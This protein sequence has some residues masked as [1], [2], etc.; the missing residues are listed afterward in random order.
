MQAYESTI[1]F[2]V[3]WEPYLLSPY[4][5]KEGVDKRTYYLQKFGPRVEAM[6]KRL[7]EVGKT[8]GISFT[9]DGTIGNTIDSHRLIEFAHRKGVQND[10]V[11]ALF[12]TYFE[13]GNNL[14]DIDILTAAAKEGGLE[15]EEV[16][17]YLQTE[18][19]REWVLKTDKKWK[20]QNINGVPCFIIDEKVRLSGA[21]DAAVFEGVFKKFAEARL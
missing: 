2:D 15:E 18:E 20:K 17:D 3:Y 13:Q 10:V 19:D 6:G 4:T 8:V 11:E 1:N 7:Q 12:K 21:Q 5:P 9:S 16:R 14:G